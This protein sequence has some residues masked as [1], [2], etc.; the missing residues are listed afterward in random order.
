MTVQRRRVNRT[1]RVLII[2]STQ[3]IKMRQEV[4]QINIRAETVGATPP[5]TVVLTFIKSKL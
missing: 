2:L 4:N 1:M 3:K 5:S